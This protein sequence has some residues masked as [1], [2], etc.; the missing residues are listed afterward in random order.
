M[1]HHAVQLI[2]QAITRNAPVCV[3]SE[4]EK[5]DGDRY[6]RKSHCPVLPCEPVL[7]TCCLLGIETNCIPRKYAFS[8]NFTG[9]D[10]LKA[11]ESAYFSVE[12]YYALKYKWERNTSWFCDGECFFCLDR[13]AVREYVLKE[14]MPDRWIGYATTSYKKH[15]ALV[16]KI[17]GKNRRNWLFENTLVDCTPYD[18]MLEWWEILNEALRSG[19]GRKILETLDC[20]IFVMQKIGIT[21]WQT[22]EKWART[23][24][25]S[26]LYQFLCY[27]LPSQLEL[28]AEGDDVSDNN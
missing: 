14:E 20:P 16:A 27:L 11:P 7:A 25:R 5:K 12:G 15:G 23:R 24:Y 2:A 1:N 13:L 17:N 9:I 18:K 28:K 4:W 19:I 3:G 10:M 26:P 8:S 21:K 22:Y 6:P